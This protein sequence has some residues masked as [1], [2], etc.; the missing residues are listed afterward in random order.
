MRRHG[1]L[2]TWNAER[3]FGFIR[4]PQGGADVFVHVS[5][6]PRDGRPPVVG[7]LVS[8]EVETGPEGKSHA[9]R[10]QRAGGQAAAPRRT[11]EARAGREARSGHR[12]V[13]RW[14]AALVVV[15]GILAWQLI[16]RPEAPAPVGAPMASLPATVAPATTPAVAFRCDGRTRC[17]QMR[18]CAE[19]RYFLDHCPNTEMDGDGD[20]LP[21]EREWCSSPLDIAR[22]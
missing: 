3:G 4:L 20:G 8:F 13:G 11:P 18:S 14:W 5:A 17:P 7:E 19:A 21:C 15:L 6:F 1:T 22:D 2:A 10:I 9:L 12:G 16:S